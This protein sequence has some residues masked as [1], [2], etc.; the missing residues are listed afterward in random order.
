MV[1][2]ADGVVGYDF[3][4]TMKLQLK[5]GRDFSKD[6]ASDSIGFILNE[7]AVN[8]IGFKNPVGQA[9]IWG[10]HRG[11]VVGV[12]KDFHFNSMHQSIEPLI[13]RLD[14]NWTWGTILV[15][16]KP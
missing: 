15:R 12:I 6:I 5:E 7:T 3:V 4:K 10:N 11:L 2:F 13:M 9:M 8:K 14:E 1:S 16:T